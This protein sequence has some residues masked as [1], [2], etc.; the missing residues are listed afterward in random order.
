MGQPSHKGLAMRLNNALEMNELAG[1]TKW[2]IVKP[3]QKLHS[4][5]LILFT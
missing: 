1:F 2:A 4:F 3:T 5:L